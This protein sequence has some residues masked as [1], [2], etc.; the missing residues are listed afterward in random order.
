MRLLIAT[1]GSPYSAVR[2]GKEIA[3]RA[4][5][6][7]AVLTVIKSEQERSQAE[8]I[9]AG[10]CELLKPQVPEAQTRIRVGH[11]AEEVICEAEEGNYDLIT[12]GDRQHYDRITRFFLGSTAQRIVEYAPCPVIIAKGEIQ[13]IRRILLCDSGADSSLLLNRTAELVN[14]I[15]R[16]VDITVLHVMSQMS[17]GPGVIGRQLRASA[18]ELVQKHTPEGELLAQ[19]VEAL[20]QLN[21]NP[22]P[23]VRH[24]LVVEEI[25]AEAHSQD[26]DLL[27]IGAHRGEGWHRVLLDDLARQIIQKVDRPIYVAKQMTE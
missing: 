17:A 22:H 12:V 9:L 2:M 8:A 27:V 5:K 23:K 4:D 16:E 19:D 21:V 20:A 26:Y 15:G 11:P 18:A 25:L 24:G 3:R 6:T 14:L 7:P 13:P 1:S 10:A